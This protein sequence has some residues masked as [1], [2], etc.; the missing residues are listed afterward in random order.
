M[1]TSLMFDQNAAT[2]TC[3][4]T[5]GPVT[6][7]T[8]FVNNVMIPL[9][10][11]YFETRTIVSTMDATYRAVLSANDANSFIGEVECIVSNNGGESRRN[12]TVDSEWGG[13]GQW[14]EWVWSVGGYGQ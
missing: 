8:W 10:S 13:R 12:I 6:D 7:V 4:S 11:V 1:V 2:V 5:G 9:G 3:L 14:Y